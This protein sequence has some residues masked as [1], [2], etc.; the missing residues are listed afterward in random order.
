[1]NS[2]EDM[3]IRHF[4]LEQSNILFKIFVF[5]N[6]IFIT[7]PM[8]NVRMMMLAGIFGQPN[9][10]FFCELTNWYT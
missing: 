5:Q 10:F 8:R 2:K 1:M 6:L 7:G 4:G 3:L 9:K